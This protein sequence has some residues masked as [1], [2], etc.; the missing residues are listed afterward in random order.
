MR[1]RNVLAI[2]KERSMAD[3]K[4]KNKDSERHDHDW[5]FSQVISSTRGAIE[6]L[7]LTLSEE[8]WSVIDADRAELQVTR[9][10]AP[11]KSLQDAD[12]VIRVPLKSSASSAAVRFRFLV[13]HKSTI[14]Y[15][16]IFRQVLRYQSGLYALSREPVVTLIVNNGATWRGGSTMRFRDWLEDP[17][18]V[19]WRTYGAN[20][21]QFD[22][23]VVNLQD[24]KVQ[25]RLLE[26][27]APVAAGLYAMGVVYGE[28]DR[29]IGL[30][31]I[32]KSS[33]FSEAEIGQIWVPVVDYLKY[34]HERLT[35][36]WWTQLELHETGESKMAEMA[37]SSIERLR[38]EGWQ[39][40]RQEERHDLAKR[41][42]QDGVDERFVRKYFDLDEEQFRLIVEERDSE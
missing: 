16:D 29:E 30:N 41:M 34:H 9:S 24:S 31:L 3:P 35:M 6:A 2:E 33:L 12:A 32:R 18:E 19:F 37:L 40:G 21:N 14:R 22:A 20:V 15:G 38:Q 1:V 11:N 23:I 13:E 8:Q 25:Q 27:D 36:E 4:A 42:L 26:S 5:M 39:E 17:G 10:K 7:R 28:I